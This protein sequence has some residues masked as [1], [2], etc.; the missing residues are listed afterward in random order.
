MSFQFSTADVD[1]FQ[2]QNQCTFPSSTGAVVTFEGKVRDHNYGRS[3]T[4]LEYEAYQE[5][6]V[7]EGEKIIN[8]AKNKFGVIQATCIHRLGLLNVGDCAV[9]ITVMASHR[10]QAFKACRYIIDEI[11]TR[12]PIWKKETYNDES[13]QWVNCQHEQL[14]SAELK[15]YQRQLALPEVSLAKQEKLKRSKVLVVGAGGLGCP[16]L[17][18]LA[19][20]GVGTIGICDF[21]IVDESNLHRQVLFDTQDIG[22]LKTEIAKMKLN[23]LNPFVK[24]VLHSH[25]LTNENI[26][27]NYDLVVDCTDNLTTKLLVNELAIKTNMP[28]IQASVYQYEGQIHR[29][30]PEQ[31][32]CLGCLW[33]FSE[34]AETC[35]QTGT[36]GAVTGTIG[37][38]QAV[39]AIKFLLDVPSP[40]ADHL[41]LFDL[42][43]LET[44]LIKSVKRLDC[45]ICALNKRNYIFPET[46]DVTYEILITNIQDLE[47]YILMD[48]LK[49]SRPGFEE[50]LDTNVNYLIYCYHGIASRSQA[51]R[52][53]KSG[54]KNIYSLKM[55]LSGN[56][57]V[58]EWLKGHVQQ[59]VLEMPA[60]AETNAT[61]KVLKI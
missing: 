35:S 33:E 39:E 8:E 2:L 42:T 22:F 27:S 52:L 30:T 37:S 3:V 14:S 51:Q 54:W 55:G 61:S 15:Y 6:A 58:K 29:W 21:D 16:V 60:E 34:G 11:K 13:S 57:I 46:T 43:S 49:A 24:I 41:I 47:K 12:L 4:L 36:I 48:A 45:K 25:V 9:W 19:S 32:Q 20:A 10:V 50:N 28:L 5:L 59:I 53:R 26:F 31:G 18:Y 7:M 44:R 1:Y 23:K 17:V 56:P 40:L 38:L